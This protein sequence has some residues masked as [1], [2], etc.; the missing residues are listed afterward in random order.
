MNNSI[1]FQEEVKPKF[2]ADAETLKHTSGYYTFMNSMPVS[3]DSWVENCQDCRKAMHRI[4]LT[5]DTKVECMNVRLN[6]S[7][8]C[9]V[10]TSCGYARMV[11]QGEWRKIRINN[12]DK[13]SIERIKLPPQP[14]ISQDIKFEPGPQPFPESTQCPNCHAW[15]SVEPYDEGRTHHIC[16]RCK[17]GEIY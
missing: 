14:I 7:Q 15:R 11:F 16:P 1:E 12:E 3:Q 10:C 5:P 4:M 2:Y 6:P 8:D 9:W 13:L 17:T